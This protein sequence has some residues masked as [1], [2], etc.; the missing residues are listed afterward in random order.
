MDTLCYDD[1][2]TPV[3]GTF[4]GMKWVQGE[5]AVVMASHLGT[6][7]LPGLSFSGGTRP[8]LVLGKMGV[9]LSRNL[10]ITITN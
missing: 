9:I 8:V 2:E 3:S 10:R 6:S 5:T 1:L 4:V 7:S